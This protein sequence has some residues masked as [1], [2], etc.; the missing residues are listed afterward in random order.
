MAVEQPQESDDPLNPL[1]VSW[2]VL[3]ELFY[4]DQ[5]PWPAGADGTG[6]PLVRTGISRWGA[7]SPTDTDA[8]QLHDAW[9]NAFF[10]SLEEWA[11][12][13][14]DNDDFSNLEEQIAGTIPTNAASYFQIDDIAAPTIEWTAAPGRTYSIYWSDDLRYSFYRIASGISDSCYTDT[15]HTTNGCSFYFI[16]VE[17]E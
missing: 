6:Y 14:W 1:D 3:D 10:G 2:A 13:D 17:M 11:E 7:P 16:T 4:F 9:E 8:D 12:D 5:A 15:D